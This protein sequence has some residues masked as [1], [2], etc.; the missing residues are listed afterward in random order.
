[1]AAN[2]VLMVSTIPDT[3]TPAP[4]GP[5][6]GALGEVLDD[7]AAVLDRL[8]GFDPTVLADPQLGCAIQRVVELARRVPAGRNVLMAEA[9]VRALPRVHRFASPG[10]YLRDLVR[11]TATEGN[12]WARAAQALT[13]R[14]PVSGGEVLPPRCPET[15]AAVAD[16]A[17][18]DTHVRHLLTTMRL[19][20]AS[21]SPAE[22]D[23]WEALLAR[24]ARVLDPDQLDTACKHVLAGVDPDGDGDRDH[25]RARRRGFTIGRQGIDGMTPVRGALTP[26]AAAM[27]RSALDPLA[28]PAPTKDAPDTA[29]RRPDPPRRRRQRH[30]GRARHRRDRPARRQ[31][32]APRR[33]TPT[34]RPHRHRH[35]LHL[36]R[37][38]NPR[39]LVRRRPLRSVPH[40]QED[41]HQRPRPPLRLPPRLRRHPRLDLPPPQRPGLVHPT[42]LDRPGTNTPNKRILQTLEN[43][44]GNFAVSIVVLN[45]Q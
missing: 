7:F 22:R 35:R 12:A 24:Q 28:A 3:P 10:T 18:G 23:G 43:V 16:G 11:C 41:Q 26:I 36:A 19:M 2:S 33:R 13:P 8:A 25:Q 9:L 30:P 32:T 38:L 5:D 21:V 27:L 42:T 29:R 20:P 6:L 45:A 1:M 39:R 31:G 44:T 15:A 37:L 17:I 40:L 4:P 34:P 14:P